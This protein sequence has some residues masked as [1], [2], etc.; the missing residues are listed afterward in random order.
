MVYRRPDQKKVWTYAEDVAIFRAYYF[1]NKPW[2]QIV[3]DT[4]IS[5]KTSILERSR[6]KEHRANIARYLELIKSQ[7]L[8]HMVYNSYVIRTE[9]GKSRNIRKSRSK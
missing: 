2:T 3:E 4:G 8:T 7:L 9:P 6:N 1:D 5:N